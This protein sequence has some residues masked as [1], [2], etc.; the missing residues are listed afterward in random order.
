MWNSHH[1]CLYQQPTT[2]S[3][4]F[5]YP[6][7]PAGMT[8]A[9]EARLSRRLVFFS[10]LCSDGRLWSKPPVESFTRS[11]DGSFAR[12]FDD[13]FVRSLEGSCDR[14]LDRSFVRSLDV[15]CVCFLGG[16]LVRSLK[17]SFARSLLLSETIK[18]VINK[19]RRDIK[20]FTKLA[21]KYSMCASLS[22]SQ[23]LNTKWKQISGGW[24]MEKSRQL[25]RPA[26]LA[27]YDS[28]DSTAVPLTFTERTLMFARRKFIGHN[29]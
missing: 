5:F 28:V 8:L 24:S 1:L 25:E 3:W 2:A 27:G 12:S 4:L 14:S 20:F 21:R 15:S 23:Y 17:G 19:L 9:T 26:S 13:F 10:S 7:P 16:S 18:G 22:A 6:N 11:F 29:A